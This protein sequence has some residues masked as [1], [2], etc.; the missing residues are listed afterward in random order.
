MFEREKK[1]V[2]NTALEIKRCGL[3][4][5]SGGNVSLRAGDGQYLVTP[6]GMI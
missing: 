2:L 3:V 1:Q 4:S 6:S 5:L